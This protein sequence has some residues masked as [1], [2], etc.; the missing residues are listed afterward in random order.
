MGALAKYWGGTRGI[1]KT[2]LDELFCQNKA[3]LVLFL[4]EVE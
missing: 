3:L 2:D 1:T 4:R